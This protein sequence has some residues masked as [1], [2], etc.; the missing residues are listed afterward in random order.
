MASEQKAS[1]NQ[2]MGDSSVARADK[3]AE[4][5]ACPR[6]GCRG[7]RTPYDVHVYPSI[8]FSGHL[9]KEGGLIP[10]HPKSYFV[11]PPEADHNPVIPAK[12]GIP[13][14]FSLWTPP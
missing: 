3:R 9:K 2:Q 5:S 8:A 11:P 10:A 13:K 14:G 6:V 7:F 4:D 1:S 12:A